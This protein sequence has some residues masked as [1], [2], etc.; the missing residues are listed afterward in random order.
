MTCLYVSLTD[1]IEKIQKTTRENGI[2]Y[3]HSLIVDDLFCLTYNTPI[4][5]IT[6]T[7]ADGESYYQMEI[8]PKIAENHTGLAIIQEAVRECKRVCAERLNEEMETA[9]EE[10]DGN[11]VLSVD[12]ILK[13]WEEVK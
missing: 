3:F 13:M 8:N 4:G 6:L 10:G 1:V 7:E 12:E 11:K 5:E 9:F 2:P